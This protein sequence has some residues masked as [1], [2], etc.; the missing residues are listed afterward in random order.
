[1]ITIKRQEVISLD[2]QVGDILQMKKSHPCGEYN[3]LVLRVGMDFKIKCVKC[4]R[5]VMLPR[6]KV[7]KNIKKIIRGEPF[8]AI[9]LL[10]SIL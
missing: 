4:G 2:V 3:F 8:G 10:K 5:Q 1:M 6:A 7:E 9:Y